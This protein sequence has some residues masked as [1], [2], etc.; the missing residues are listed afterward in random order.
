MAG[1]TPGQVEAGKNIVVDDNKDIAGFNKLSNA[2]LTLNGVDLTSTASELNKLN[3]VTDGAVTSGK[4]VI[5]SADSS[6]WC[7]R[8]VYY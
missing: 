5:A 8:P 1:V 4:V 2:S 6:V 3:G 7:K